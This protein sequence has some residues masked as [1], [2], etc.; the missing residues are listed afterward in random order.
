MLECMSVHI[1]LQYKCLEMHVR[2][3][4]ISVSNGP[5][6]GRGPLGQAAVLGELSPFKPKTK[7]TV[8]MR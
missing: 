1:L 4:G 2:V 5:A 6:W 8:A 3:L 7:S